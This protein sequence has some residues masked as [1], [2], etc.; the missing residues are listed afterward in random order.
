MDLD[1]LANI[2]VVGFQI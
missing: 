1:L 2:S